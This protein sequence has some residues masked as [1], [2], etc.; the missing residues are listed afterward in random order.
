VIRTADAVVVGGGLIGCAVGRELARRGARVAIVERGAVGAEA[1]TA[2]AG[3]I[4]PQAESPGPGP[5]LRLG[6]LS[7]ARY[8]AWVAALAEESGVDPEYTAS[9]IVYVALDAADVRVLAARAR[10]QQAEGLRVERLGARAARRLVPGLTPRVRMALY[11]V[12]D[13]PI[14]NARLVVAAAR[15]AQRAG[16][17]LLVH[18]PALAVVA[19]RGRVA[20]LETP[21]GTIATPIVVNAAGAWAGLLGL[22]AGVRPPRVF[23][24][25]GQVVVLRGAP[26][27]LAR[28]VYSRRGYVVPRADGRVLAGSTLERAGFEKRVTAGAASAILAAAL[29]MVPGLAALTV[30]RAYAGLRPGTPDQLPLLGP[31]PDLPGL[32]YATGHYRSGI[33]LAPVT[34]EAIADLVLAGRTALPVAAMR[35][36]RSR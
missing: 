36:R 19:R 33:L 27:A 16:A 1:S 26:G 10:W 23:P 11:F 13:H 28:P 22:P 8:R 30:E 21:A 6:V 17:A 25:R 7:R 20:G 18:T 14:D 5:L 12:D 32:F 31:A 9:G 15:A 29:A 35:P 3:M 34:A 2:A 4:A 24:V